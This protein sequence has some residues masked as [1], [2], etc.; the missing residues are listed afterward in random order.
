MPI[1]VVASGNPHKVAEIGAMLELVELDVLPQPPGLD[2]EETGATY[3]ANARLKAEA[4]ARITGHWALADDSG[5]E[6][7][8]LD[9]APG[10]F[11]ARYAPTDHERI[12]RLLKELGDSLYRG[13][14]FRSAMALA[15]PSGTTRAEAEGIC[16]GQ[17]LRA[18]QGHG[19]GYDSLFYVREAGCSYALMGPHLK[20]KLGSRGKA[21][22]ALAPK[23]LHLLELSN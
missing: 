21:A 10:I 17:I 4:V 15:D 19:P 11:S 13:A 3:L 20:A 14:S 18:P 8:A 2:I 12:H 22:R 1:L 9:G 6:V 5:I 23:L 16:R 7:D